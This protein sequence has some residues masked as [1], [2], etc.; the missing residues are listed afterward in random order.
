ML[1]LP[2]MQVHTQIDSTLEESRFTDQRYETGLLSR[3][4]E[5]VLR[6]LPVLCY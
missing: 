6:V 2:T 4:S 5:Q 3:Q 1:P